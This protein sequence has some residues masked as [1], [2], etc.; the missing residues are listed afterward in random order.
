MRIGL[1]TILTLI[2]LALLLRIIDVDLPGVD[3]Y[4]M[5]VLFT[6]VGV[7]SLLLIV[8]MNAMRRQQTT[9]VI[10]HESEHESR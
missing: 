10:E 6:I 3:D 7:A 5:G 2:G 8:A 9:R 1:S 4:R